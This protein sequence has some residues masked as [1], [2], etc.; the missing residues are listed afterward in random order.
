VK[1]AGGERRAPPAGTDAL[2]V[3]AAALASSAEA[4]VLFVPVRSLVGEAAGVSSG[5]LAHYPWFVLLIVAATAGVTLVGGSRRAVSLLAMGAVS[6]GVIQATVWGSGGLVAVG[7]G[8]VICLLLALRVAMLGTRDWRE[9]ASESF[10][11]GAALL[12]LE[13]MFAWSDPAWRGILIVATP[14]FFLGMLSSRAASLHLASRPTGPAAPEDAA[15]RGRASVAAV[16]ALGVVLGAAVALGGKGGALEAVGAWSFGL[17]G[18]AMAVA[19]GALARLLFDPLVWV[20]SQLNLDIPLDEVA[21]RLGRLSRGRPALPAGSGGGALG[22]V[23]G[24][25]V[26]ALLVLLL[27]RTIRR[28]WLPRVPLGTDRAPEAPVPVHPITRGKPRARPRR[29]RLRRELPSDTVRRWYAE[30]LVALELVG[31]ARESS[32]TPGEYL[33]R[34]ERILPQWAGSF[35]A[36]TRAYEEVRYG[37]RTVESQGLD[38]L[39]AH[40]AYLLRG[41][42]TAVPRRD[43]GQIGRK[44]GQ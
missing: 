9:P 20:F 19:V 31:L 8:I 2:A 14:H 36:L 39:E 10:L 3:P 44:G 12:L 37:G 6:L 40:R 22:R 16:A 5:P 1:D 11:L 33:R 4:A 38:R 35:G 43:G 13:A 15:R 23:L 42:R 25:V 7:A 34:V 29:S 26:L 18:R 41:L 17:V 21:E 28:Y 32:W 30:A 24:L 27:I